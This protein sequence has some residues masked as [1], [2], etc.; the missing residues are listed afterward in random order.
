MT[1][2]TPISV[3]DV[4]L[5]NCVPTAQ[6]NY[7]RPNVTLPL[8]G[9]TIYMG[10]IH[11][12]A[13]GNP[14]LSQDERLASIDYIADLSAALPGRAA[15]LASVANYVMVAI[16]TSPNGYKIYANTINEADGQHGREVNPDALPCTP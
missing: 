7:C 5:P 1:F 9:G 13:N 3:G 10:D 16:S 8:V 11:S 12:H 15:Q 4:V 6:N 2:T 14:A